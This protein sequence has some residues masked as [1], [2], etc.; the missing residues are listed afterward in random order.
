MGAGGERRHLEYSHRSVPHDR[1]RGGD[2]GR[3]QGPGERPDIHADG[4][5]GNRFAGGNGMLGGGADGAGGDV[6]AG[7]QQRG[8]ALGGAPHQVAGG[9]DQVRLH[10]RVA[11]RD[12]ACLQEGVGHGA[13][14]QQGVHLGHQVLQD[15]DLGGDL[16]AA[17]DCHERLRRGGEQLRQH[18]HLARHEQPGGGGQVVG[19][20]RGGG[21]GAMRGAERIVHVDAAQ[22]R[23]AAREAGVAGLLLG[24][25]AQVL[26][27]HHPARRQCG[28]K[29][30]HLG[31]D[32]VGRHGYRAP[33][34]AAEV[35]G[36]RRQAQLRAR[37]ALGPSQVA[38]QHG[39]GS[40]LL[41]DRVQ[42]GEG[43]A[44]PRIVADHPFFE[45]HVEVHPQQHAPAFQRKIGQ[46]AHFRHRYR[47]SPAPPSAP[48]GAPRRTT[49]L[50]LATR[51]PSICWIT[52]S[53]MP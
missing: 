37:G 14:D 39:A 23:Q 35:R 44:D 51:F 36:H 18:R 28:G 9:G 22:R 3:E 53:A 31:A 38:H 27:Q 1:P 19:H 7:Q 11:H 25:E 21:V 49:T 42:R 52:K 12:A 43:R 17:D 46:P 15:R 26:Q 10:Q 33:E 30:L 50:T 32:T 5:A 47:S 8:P 40:R 6:V 13:A 48:A 20:H 4:A 24:V 29:T 2:A 41:E 34:Q 45:R 16:G